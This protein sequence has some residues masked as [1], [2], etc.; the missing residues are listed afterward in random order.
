MRQSKN[1][2]RWFP[3]R[4]P[5]NAE[6]RRAAARKFSVRKINNG[7]NAIAAQAN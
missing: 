5:P 7:T 2:I 3:K 1:K 6:I 4:Q